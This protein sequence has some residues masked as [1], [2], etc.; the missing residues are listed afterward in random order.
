LSSDQH[1]ADSAAVDE[2]MRESFPASDPP[3]THLPDKPPVNVRKRKAPVQ[4]PPFGNS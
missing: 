3:S 2:A 4:R 1:R